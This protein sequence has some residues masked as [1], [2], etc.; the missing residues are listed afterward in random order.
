M[1][2]A[3]AGAVAAFSPFLLSLE[4]KDAVCEFYRRNGRVGPTG[5]D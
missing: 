4:S 5:V 1:A 2:A 3:G